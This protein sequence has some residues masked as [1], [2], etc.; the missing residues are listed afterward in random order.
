M[1]D[2]IGGAA[3]AGAFLAVFLGYAL[4]FGL[5]SL[6]LPVISADEVSALSR[7]MGQGSLNLYDVLALKGPRILFFAAQFATE[8][9]GYAFMAGF[10]VMMS[11]KIEN[12]F[13]L[14]SV[15]IMFYYG[16]SFLAALFKAPG[17][18]CWYYVMN[19]GG[20]LRQIA[21]SL[22]ILMLLILLYFGSLIC[23]EGIVYYFWMKRRKIY[24]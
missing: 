14:L 11:V 4:C 23:L 6:K 21:P 1:T 9:L 2:Q 24:G 13:V 7:Q 19:G 15:P 5:L 17:I 3:S 10:A 8:G 20:W 12:V 16:S 18:F 22:G